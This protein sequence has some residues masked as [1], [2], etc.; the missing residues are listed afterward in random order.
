MN[1]KMSSLEFQRQIMFLK[2]K[3]EVCDIM[4]CFFICFCSTLLIKKEKNSEA[5][6]VFIVDDLSKL[7][8]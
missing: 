8:N 6:L 5:T 3:M 1:S 7:R 2:K 4:V